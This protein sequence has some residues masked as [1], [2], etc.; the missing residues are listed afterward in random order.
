MFTFL[1]FFIC[2]LIYFF[3][4]AARVSPSHPPPPVPAAKTPVPSCK[5]LYDFDPEQ[6]QELPFKE[7]DVIELKNQVDD[8]WFEGTV[9]G[10]T[11]MFPIAYVRVLVPLNK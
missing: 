9:N 3:K 1:T 6:E 2:F 4:N 11:G 10:K 8:N 7:G 5:A